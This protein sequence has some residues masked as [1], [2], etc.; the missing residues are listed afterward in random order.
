VWQLATTYVLSFETYSIRR[1]AID[2]GRELAPVERKTRSVEVNG[3]SIVIRELV[4]TQVMLL[5]REA[6]ILQ[7]DDVSADR[8]I[9]GIDKMFS[10]LESVVV[11]PEDRFYLEG[12]MVL[13]ELDLRELVS[14]VTSFETGD[15][16]PVRVRRGRAP[17]KR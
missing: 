6:K 11:E 15:E 3:R 4:D 5:A 13:G 7:R 12:L 16:K 14:F 2:P 9:D 17:A 10:I 8:K 1:M